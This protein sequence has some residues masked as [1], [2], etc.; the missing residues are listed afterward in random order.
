MSTYTEEGAPPIG[1]GGDQDNGGGG[2]SGHDNP[3][4][5]AKNTTGNAR[6]RRGRNGNTYEYRYA[7]SFKG[8]TF[9]MN[10]HV[11]ELHSERKLRRNS[12]IRWRH[13]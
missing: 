11:F 2:F 9:K 4:T 3:Q 1:T 10:G 12:W 7:K 13:L 6:A 8:E 5:T